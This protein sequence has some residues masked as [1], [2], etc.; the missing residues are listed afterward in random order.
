MPDAVH[1]SRIN[2]RFAASGLSTLTSHVCRKEFASERFGGQ[3]IRQ[4]GLNSTAG[5]SDTNRW[6]MAR[7]LHRHIA[8]YYFLQRSLCL[9]VWWH[10]FLVSNAG[11][12]DSEVLSS[13]RLL[14]SLKTCRFDGEVKF[15]VPEGREAGHLAEAL[16]HDETK[17]PARHI[18]KLTADKSLDLKGHYS[19]HTFKQMLSSN[20]PPRPCRKSTVGWLRVPS[21]PFILT[22]FLATFWHLR[23]FQGASRESLGSLWAQ[24]TLRT[25]CLEA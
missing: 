23:S 13:E 18:I 21:E 17:T 7:K 6:T 25:L 22:R 16:M 2:F 19:T 8:V 20:V 3:S 11:L 14:S 24:E 5:F 9:Q 4:H 15:H 1:E 12:W 10:A